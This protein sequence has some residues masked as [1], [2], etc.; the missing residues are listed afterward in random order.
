M[1][2]D[3]LTLLVLLATP[4]MHAKP[5]VIVLGVPHLCVA[6]PHH[7]TDLGAPQLQQMLVIDQ[8]TG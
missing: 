1:P 4:L 3:L 5:A 6:S 2:P 7:H 8:D